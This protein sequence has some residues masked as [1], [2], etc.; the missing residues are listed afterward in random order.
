MDKLDFEIMK[1]LMDNSRASFRKIAKEL[2]V[3]TDTVMR[4]YKKLKKNG[5]IKPTISINLWKFG[6]QACTWYMISLR[7]QINISSALD[8]IAKIPN[9][10]FIIKAVGDYDLM[11][12]AAVKSFQH[13]YKI[14]DDLAKVSG[15]TK[16]EGRPYTGRGDPEVG[17]AFV[18]G[19]YRT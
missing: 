18:R 4:R 14:G 3:S 13:M 8:E 1:K 2:D 16:I 17:K 9:I 10:I 12:I 11:A 5:T 19:F 7:P 15:V 6:Y